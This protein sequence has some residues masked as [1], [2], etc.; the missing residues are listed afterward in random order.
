LKNKGEKKPPWKAKCSETI[1]LYV[2][3]LKEMILPTGTACTNP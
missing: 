2:E 1:V 3:E